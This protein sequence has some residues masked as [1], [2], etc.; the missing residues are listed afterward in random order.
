MNS[1]QVLLAQRPLEDYDAVVFFGVKRLVYKDSVQLPPFT[2]ESIELRHEIQIPPEQ[3]VE[4]YSSART[5]GRF[6]R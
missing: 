4:W 1:K 6:A 2:P 5:S 3:A